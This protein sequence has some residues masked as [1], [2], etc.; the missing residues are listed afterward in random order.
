MRNYQLIIE[1]NLF[2][3]IEIQ[4]FFNFNVFLL[5]KKQY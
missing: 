3:I 2:Q 4:G 1:E 5:I